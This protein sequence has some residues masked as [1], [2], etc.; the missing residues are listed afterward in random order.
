MNIILFVNIY[1]VILGIVFFLKENLHIILV[2]NKLKF[3]ISTYVIVVIISNKMLPLLLCH[4][5]L[6][7]I[8]VFELYRVQSKFKITYI[9]Q[10]HDKRM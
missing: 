10:I 2:T 4:L 6:A 7:E 3:D 8:L 9:W 1:I 5:I